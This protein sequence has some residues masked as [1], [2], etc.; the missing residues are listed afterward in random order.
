MILTQPHAIFSPHVRHTRTENSA[1]SASDIF[2]Q[3]RRR[4]C[5]FRCADL[6]PRYRS[7]GVRAIQSRTVYVR[8]ST[9]HISRALVS[10]RLSVRLRVGLWPSH[11]ASISVI[12]RTVRGA[13]ISRRHSC[14]RLRRVLLFISLAKTRVCYCVR[15]SVIIGS[16]YTLPWHP[17]PRI[18]HWL[19]GQQTTHTMWLHCCRCVCAGPY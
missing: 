7:L 14:V 12:V 19:I 5:C 8:S 13:V 17:N 9:R 10:V 11:C 6:E 1:R 3:E 2:V 18:Y 16:V 4:V 15:A